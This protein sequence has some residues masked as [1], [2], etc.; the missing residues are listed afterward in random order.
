MTAP[1]DL[2][3]VPVMFGN[4]L[5]KKLFGTSQLFQSTETPENVLELRFL[6][7]AQQHLVLDAA[8]KRLVTQLMWF[9]VGRKNQECL[10]RNSHLAAAQKREI[11]EAALHRYDTTVQQ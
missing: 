3:G 11:V 1:V 5:R 8:E 4:E 7:T 9:K 6:W 10:E 2:A